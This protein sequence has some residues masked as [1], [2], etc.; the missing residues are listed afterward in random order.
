MPRLYRRCIFLGYGEETKGYQLYDSTKS[1]VFY[2]REVRFNASKQEMVPKTDMPDTEFLVE[3]D[4]SNDIE[5]SSK[6]SEEELPFNNTIEPVLRRSGRERRRPDFYGLK[7]NTVG[8][9]KNDPASIEEALQ[10][11][12]RKKW[13]NVMEQEMKSLEENE[14]W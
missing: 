4:F 2:S 1:R 9:L 14:V 5:V 11:P 13:M 3:L 8:E 6:D 7:A 10:S 12:K